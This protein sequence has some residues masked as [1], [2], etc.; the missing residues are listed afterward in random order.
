MDLPYVI[1]VGEDK[2]S[3]SGK[4]LNLA[5]TI[6]LTPQQKSMRRSSN[7]HFKESFDLEWLPGDVSLDS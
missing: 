7:R 3:R 5:T 2:M 1:K 6:D 4:A